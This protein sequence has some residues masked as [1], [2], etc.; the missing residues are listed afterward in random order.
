MVPRMAEDDRRNETDGLSGPQTGGQVNR[1]DLTA[2]GD[3]S[4]PNLPG[5]VDGGDGLHGGPGSGQTGP[6]AGERNPGE[7]IRQLGGMGLGDTHGSTG[8]SEKASGSNSQGG[9][10]GPGQG[11]NVGGTG[12]A[13]GIGGATGSLPGA[14]SSPADRGFG[15]AEPTGG[16][17]GGTSGSGDVSLNGGKGSG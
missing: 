16:D 12:S 2:G 10:G 8:A 17:L 11:V 6:E 3:D 9:A 4:L 13:G 1:A 14:G 5:A 7:V 15:S